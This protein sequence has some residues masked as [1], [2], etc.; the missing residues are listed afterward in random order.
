M[1]DEE[2]PLKTPTQALNERGI[3]V[4]WTVEDYL[5]ALLVEIR[6]LR[7]VGSEPGDGIPAAVAEAA[8]EIEAGFGPSVL[9]VM[10]AAE[11][12]KQ[13]QESEA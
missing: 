11:A 10:K 7:M 3:G 1:A 9:D 13:E 5:A 8:L 4:G 6:Q 2:T 12:E